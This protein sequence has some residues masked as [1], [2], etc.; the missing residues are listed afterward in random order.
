VTA[1]TAAGATTATPGVTTSSSAGLNE[2]VPPSSGGAAGGSSDVVSP[3][4]GASP[5]GTGGSAEPVVAAAAADRPTAVAQQ[6][7]AGD[8]SGPLISLVRSL[9]PPA[10]S[11]RGPENVLLVLAFVVPALASVIGTRL[12]R[13]VTRLAATVPA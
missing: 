6:T 11:P 13:R 10:P 3:A 8:D 7:S 12:A 1:N 4:V 2:A 9:S 5:A